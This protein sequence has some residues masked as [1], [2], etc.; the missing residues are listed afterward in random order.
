M[1]PYDTIEISTYEQ[2]KKI[3]T[4]WTMP[5]SANYKLTNNINA[6]ASRL[7]PSGAGLPPIGNLAH[8]FSGS[9]NGNGFRI[10]KLYINNTLGYHTEN[11]GF[12]GVTDTNAIIKNLGVTGVIHGGA[13]TGG[14]VGYNKGTISL[15][16][17]GGLITAGSRVGG[18]VGEN[19]GIIVKC[20]SNST[21]EASSSDIGGL[22]GQNFDGSIYDSYS[23]GMVTSTLVSDYSDANAGGL[24]GWNIGHIERCYS[25]GI[26]RGNR[27]V[28][29]LIGYDSPYGGSSVIDSYWNIYT[30]RLDTSSQSNDTNYKGI[31]EGDMMRHQTYPT[32]WEFFTVWRI[33][34]RD[35]Y[36]T[37]WINYTTPISHSDQYKIHSRAHLSTLLEND[38]NIEDGVRPTVL[39]IDSIVG[40]GSTD[41]TGWYMLPEGAT[42]YEKDTVFYR[43]GV[44]VDSDTIWSNTSFSMIY[45]D[46]QNYAPRAF[47]DL[48]SINEGGN[49]IILLS[50]L[51]S[52]DTDYDPNTYFT[53]DELQT[54]SIN[55]GIFEIRSD[56]LFYTSNEY[57]N[58]TEAIPYILSDG[59]LTDTA[60][61]IITVNPVNDTTIFTTIQSKTIN[62]DTDFTI[63]QQITDIHNVD[64]DNLTF[65][66]EEGDNYT[67]SGTTI[68]P[69]HN[70]N[71]ELVIPI[72]VDDGTDVIGPVDF[73]LTVT[74]V[75]DLPTLSLAHNQTIDEDG[76]IELTFFMTDAK[77]D[78]NDP[79]QVIIVPH[80]DVVITDAIV[81]P[82]ENF[83]GTIQLQI[84]ITDG[85]E[86]TN[87]VPM[88]LIVNSVNDLPELN[89]VDSITTI[90]E[91][92]VDVST[93][94]YNATD[95]EGE[96]LS[97]IVLSDS[98]YVLR[99]DSILPHE[100]FFGALSVPVCVSD[101]TDR[102]DTIQLHIQVDAVDDPL[103]YSKVE[104]KEIDEDTALEITLSMTDAVDVDDPLSVIIRSGSEYTIVGNVITPTLH[105]NGELLVPVAITN[106]RDT[107]K[108]ISMTIMVTPVN[109]VPQVLLPKSQKINEDTPIVF[110]ND[111]V[112]L[113]DVDNENLNILV[114]HGEHYTVSGLTVTPESNFN[115]ALQVPVSATDG[116]DTSQSV[117]LSVDVMPVNDAPYIESI[118]PLSIG[119]NT[120]IAVADTLI[121]AVDVDGDVLSIL[122]GFSDYFTA[123]GTNVIAQDGFTGRLAIPIQVTDGLAVSKTDTLVVHV[124]D[125]SML[126]SSAQSGSE[127]SSTQID[128][129][130]TVPQPE[131]GDTTLIALPNPVDSISPITYGNALID[132]Q[133]KM[134]IVNNSAGA[135]T[136]LS[137]PN[138]VEECSIFTLRGELVSKLNVDASSVSIPMDLDAG[139]YV[140]KFTY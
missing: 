100:H 66:I 69:N 14:L 36:P 26:V 110:T 121:K 136:E 98:S 111:M 44:V 63:T 84:A 81:E 70:F 19:R 22:V 77:D 46:Y 89:K 87:Y 52:N 80:K 123:Y 125:N 33:R 50:D 129:P 11:T 53:I 57:W 73:K 27:Q 118:V 83:Y 24:V 109:D 74:P 68:I 30:S 91:V 131:R 75:N 17:T 32:T 134:V 25:T 113:L 62:E 99:N 130:V 20:Y 35:Q 60:N 16:Y 38:W 106:G 76:L 128:V 139:V 124:V 95:V 71:G 79:L 72:S 92:G 103:T 107:T 13:A 8:P 88:E 116:I 5:L 138:D 47:D 49:I 105:F 43:A 104:G 64:D 37:L 31:S 54:D 56:T 90:E 133:R 78:D 2:L 132:D 6:S 114:G 67:I 34:E 18:L 21:I 93:I 137:I 108:N 97:L 48:Y 9:F 140:L 82:V 23:V 96:N 85:T 39:K 86:T 3:G 122:I 12:F 127:V 115:G 10:Y 120:T 28:G 135:L 102:S 58:G 51:L 94:V 55:N 119:P 45:L 1:I 29:G 112:T 4:H 61:I 101:G 7:E 42:A 40:V 15:S 59:H 117:L 41:S 65:I 126:L